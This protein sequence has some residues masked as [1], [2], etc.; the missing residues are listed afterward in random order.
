MD[1]RGQASERGDGDVIA[2]RQA[3]Q[4]CGWLSITL[5]SIAREKKEPVSGDEMMG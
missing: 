4:R 1:S 5:N 3:V 2:E